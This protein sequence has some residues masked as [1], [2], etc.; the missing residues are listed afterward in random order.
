MYIYMDRKATYMKAADTYLV[1]CKKLHATGG[2]VS[3]RQQ[4]TGRQRYPVRAM[5]H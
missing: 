2:L 3:E 5:C 4:M 1:R